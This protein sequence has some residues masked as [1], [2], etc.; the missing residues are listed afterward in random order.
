MESAARPLDRRQRKSRAALQGALLTAIAAKPYENITIEDIADAADLT[1]AT[2]YAHYSDKAAL[3]R[4]ASEQLLVEVIP[5][6]RASATLRGAE[7]NGAG[8]ATLI[9]HARDHPDLYRVILSGAG[10]PE[11]RANFVSTL[12]TVTYEILRDLVA[13]HHWKPQISLTFIS[14]TFVGALIYTL[15]ITL[16]GQL[17]GTSSEIAALFLLSQSGMRWSLGAPDA[18]TPGTTPTGN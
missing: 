18:P 12:E 2:F 5:A 3:L 7:F 10:G 13:Q 4:E 9:S 16:N 1:R 14:G 6:I 11:A 15:E 8:A 17:D